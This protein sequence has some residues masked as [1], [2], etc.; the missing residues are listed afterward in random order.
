MVANGEKRPTTGRYSQKTQHSRVS[1]VRRRYVMGEFDRQKAA[2]ELTGLG[3][4]PEDIDVAVTMWN[5]IFD[6]ARTKERMFLERSNER[7]YTLPADHPVRVR[8][9]ELSTGVRLAK[10]G[11]LYLEQALED[12]NRAH[13]KQ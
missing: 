8:M 11:P 10:P 9:Q 13:P 7:I 2:V 4:T 5:V 1:E 6:N 12:W 3:F